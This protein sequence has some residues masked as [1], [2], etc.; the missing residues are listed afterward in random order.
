MAM[1]MNGE[2][3]LAVRWETVWAT[4]NDKEILKSCIPVASN[5]TNCR[6]LTFRQCLRQGSGQ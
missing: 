1:T 5:S 3:Q 4:L 6:T 2:Y